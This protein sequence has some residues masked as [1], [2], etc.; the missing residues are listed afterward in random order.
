MKAITVILCLGILV[1]VT[2]CSYNPKTADTYKI[3]LGK[4]CTPD[5]K[6][7]SYIWFHTVYGEKQV[8]K[9]WCK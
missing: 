8:K 3:L 7:F 5:S 9:E 1:L 6:K 4:K 2:A